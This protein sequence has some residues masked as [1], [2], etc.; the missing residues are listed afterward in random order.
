MKKKNYSRKKEFLKLIAASVIIG[1]VCTILGDSLKLLTDNYE[2]KFYA[3]AKSNWIF[4]FVFP[5]IGLTSIYILRQYLFRKKENKGIKEIFDSLKTRHNDLPAY[6]IPSHFINGLLTVICGGSTGIEVSTVVASASIGSVTQN[7]AKI[8]HL[9]RKELI[10]AGVAAG[11][12]ALFGSPIAG[13]LF[14]IEVILKKISKTAL[15]SILISVSTVWFF[16]HLLNSEPLFTIK[17][18]HWNH[19]A[20]PY[21]IV[22]GIFSGL[23][24]VYLTKSVLFF[25]SKFSHITKSYSK[26]LL[27]SMILSISLLLFP[28]LY[29]DGYHAM[30]ELFLYPDQIKLSYTFIFIMIG[31]LVLKPIVTATTLAS[32]GDGGV[33]APSLFIGAFLGLLLAGVLNVFFHANVIP[34][35]FM[36]VGMAA[37]LSASLH[38]PFTAVF[39]VCGL[40]NDYTLIIPILT[41]CLVSKLT[42]KMIIPYTVYSYSPINI[43]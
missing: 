14:A 34:I 18:N 12:T 10:C 24:S 31:I 37:V 8:H 3:L 35:N 38:A 43:K 9:Y 21:F 32:G 27:G 17:I 15:I 40:V 22:L 29:G 5:I 25:K 4:F 20:F 42:A 26:I 7:K 6:K 36:V 41:A 1:C 16:H 39:L 23:N 30:K 19:Y 33:F 28:Q 13:I 11:V 2:T